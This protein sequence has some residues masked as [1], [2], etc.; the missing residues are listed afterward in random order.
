MDYLDKEKLRQFD[1]AMKDRG[2]AREKAR[3]KNFKS[4]S[5]IREEARKK[6]EEKKPKSSPWLGL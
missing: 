5:E 4:P 2:A 3:E 6:Q 1:E